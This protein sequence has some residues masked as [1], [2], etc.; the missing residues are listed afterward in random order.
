MLVSGTAIPRADAVAADIVTVVNPDDSNAVLLII[1]TEV[2]MV[3]DVKEVQ[4]ANAPIRI[5]VTELGMVTDDKLVL[6]NALPPIVEYPSI[7]TLV[8]EPRLALTVS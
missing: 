4:L 7:T 2:G 1:V 8:A 6:L 3:I 5:V